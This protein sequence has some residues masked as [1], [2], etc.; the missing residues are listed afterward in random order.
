MGL[1]MSDEQGKVEEEVKPETESSTQIATAK[2]WA[3]NFAVPVLLSLLGAV[4]S[5]TK[6][7]EDARTE[8]GEVKDKSEAGY[9]GVD[10]WV[11]HL[12][13]TDDVL[14]ERIAKL[15]AEVAEVKR[16]A[17][18]TASKRKAEAAARPT[19]PPT[20][21]VPAPPP[22]PP[23]LAPTLDK[24]LEQIQHQQQKAPEKAAEPPAPK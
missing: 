23:P 9:Q 19:P 14:L 17:R 4:G 12:E 11:K 1:T 16:R 8:A 6:A 13:K 2:R 24:A 18:L 22:P 20:L 3:I 7:R 21:A 10:K 15:E 5:W